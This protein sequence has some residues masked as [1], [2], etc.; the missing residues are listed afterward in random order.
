[1]AEKVHAAWSEPVPGRELH[2]LKSGAF[3]TAHCYANYRFGS[4][5]PASRVKRLLKLVQAE[6]IRVAS[7]KVAPVWRKC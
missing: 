3:S 6:I 7:Y 4:S 1:M 5:A 2:P